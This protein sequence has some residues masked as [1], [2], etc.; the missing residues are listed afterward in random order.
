MPGQTYIESLSQY[1]LWD[2]DKKQLDAA[3]HSVQLI[4]RILERGT[5]DDWKLTR[6]FY[7]M[8][9]IV[10]DCKRMRTLN[11]KAL[12]FICALSDTKKEDY[13]CYQL[14]QSLQTHSP[15]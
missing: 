3:K 10:T 9:K 7:G 1:L 6:D 2:M 11:P 5:L 8:D 4:Q 15:Y 14:R 12:S 13:R